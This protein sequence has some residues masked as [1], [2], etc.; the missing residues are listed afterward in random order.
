[1]ASVPTVL[2]VDDEEGLRVSLQ[3]GLEAHAHEFK[4]LTASD[5]V[6]ALAMVRQVRPS[7]VVS[8]VRMPR[9][10]G[11]EL[12]LA[13]KKEF[14]EIPVVV[15]SAFFSEQLE[16]SAVAFGAAGVMHKPIDLQRL[17]SLIREVLNT[18]SNHPPE[19][20]FFSDFSLAG[21]LQL[22]EIEGKSCGL[23]VINKN[24]RRGIFWLENGQL[25]DAEAG[26]VKG[27]EAALEI[28]GW[29]YGNMNLRAYQSKTRNIEESLGF[30]LMEAAR[31]ADEKGISVA[32]EPEETTV[33]EI[34][35]EHAA[36]P[37]APKKEDTKMSNMTEIL[38]KAKVVDGFIA[39]GAFSPQ[40]ELVGEVTA[41]GTRLAEI[42]AL[43]N[44][45]LLKAQKSTDIMG[46]GRGNLVHIEAPGAHILVRC[47]NENTDFSVSEAGRAHIHVV[48]LLDKEG[49]LALGKMR[50]TSITL[51]LAPLFH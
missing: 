24:G 47:I 27:T 44:D 49:N 7:M 6:Q 31:L 23:E 36:D 4:V 1:M 11:I 22:L 35:F 38:S 42:G 48:M 20:G 16:R 17:I 51:E 25:F 28:L 33:E 50:L 2:L 26:S 13:C 14:P 32:S 12:L 30:C 5:G 45:V 40:G 19:A 41:T 18:A 3:D 37:V 15:V 9:M 46:V 29:E 21:F 39:I 34:L 43:A 10:D 8:D